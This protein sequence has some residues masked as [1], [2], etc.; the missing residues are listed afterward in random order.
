MDELRDEFIAETRETLE[1]LTGELVRWELNPGDRDILDNVFRFF[2]TVK[3]SC[4]FLNLVRFERL[5]HAAEDLLGDV[6]D[7]RRIADSEMVSVVLDLIDHVSQLTDA[8]ETGGTVEHRLDAMLLE[9]IAL[10]RREDTPQGQGA[11]EG[12]PATIDPGGFTPIGESS[13][14]TVRISLALLDQL[15]S[16]VSDLVLARNEVVRQMAD[17]SSSL[18]LDQSFGR[19]SATIA[20]LRDSVSGMRMQRIERLFAFLPRLVRDTAHK[21]GKQVDLSISGGNVEIDREMFELI[22]DPLTH[23]VRNAIDHGLEPT[24]ARREAGKP[25]KGLIT[26]MAR[27]SGNQIL[28]TV[29]DDGRGV[30]T[31]KL[32]Q[33]AIDSGLVDAAALERMDERQCLKLIFE[34]GLST[35]ADISDIS[36]RGVGM[37]IVKTNVE[38]VGGQIELDNQPGH[39]LS[40]TLSMPLTLTII[41]GLVVTVR[42]QTFAISRNSVQEIVN[43][44]SDHVRLERIGTARNVL[45]RG[46]RIVLG[47]LGEMLGIA[48]E[49]AGGAPSGRTLV[50][51]KPAVGDA[52][53]LLV[54]S[55]ADCQELV[56]RPLAP[57]IMAT[58]NYA[59]TSLPDNGCPILL[60]DASGLAASLG[61]TQNRSFDEHAD[62]AAQDAVHKEADRAMAFVDMDGR[63][64]VIRLA[65]V[66]RVEEI[67]PARLSLGNGHARI[68]DGEALLPIF[69]LGK[70]VE[71]TR[72]LPVLRLT[73]GMSTCFYAMRTLLDLVSLD[74]PLTPAHENPD[75]EAH[76]VIGGE[77]FALIDAYQ[78][79]ARIGGQSMAKGAA[80]PLC[81]VAGAQDDSW[82]KAMLIPLL[83]SAGYQVSDDPVDASQAD[84]VIATADEVPSD[85]ADARIVKLRHS[86]ERAGPNDDSVYRYDRV[87]L[88]SAIG[89]KLA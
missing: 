31:R 51:V 78:L 52:F 1:T 17:I 70:I 83:R 9:R 48:D 82:S 62:T 30:D 26:V 77:H 36:G 44:D 35:A 11:G 25:E 12:P 28:V 29:T 39:G 19:L 27:Q 73:D 67:D 68:V 20:D 71:G 61:C 81:F 75:L 24:D 64:M 47:V 56:V 60:L 6:R 85:G 14:R 63:N 13:P 10:L 34:P 84:V 46:K 69:G 18:A 74:N 40:I 54:D 5:S 57:A 8:I 16:G 38:S 58:G 4:G 55:V 86:P 22:R 33:K 65:V 80:S 32:A 23:I 53:G 88:L 21:L 37:D 41:A 45:I 2:H 66:D 7:Q 72:L 49:D 89:E 3:G 79:F 59:G 50:V 87:R 15:M 76:T 42:G 43:I